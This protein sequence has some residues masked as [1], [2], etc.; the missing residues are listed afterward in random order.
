MSRRLPSQTPQGRSEV[1][2]DF[3]LTE[4]PFEIAQLRIG[5][6]HHQLHACDVREIL[7]VLCRHT[8]AVARVMSPTCVNPRCA[9][10]LEIRPA[11]PHGTRDG[12]LRQRLHPFH[13]I[14]SSHPTP[15]PTTPPN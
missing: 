14:P 1:V 10:C 2:I 12:P 11:L 13:S 15:K 5:V 8:I 6:D 3:V 7:H 9:S 4:I